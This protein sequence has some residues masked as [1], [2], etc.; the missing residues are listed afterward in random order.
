MTVTEATPHGTQVTPL[1]RAQRKGGIYGSLRQ[2]SVVLTF[3][4][5]VEAA[6]WDELPDGDLHYRLG[7]L[8]T[9]ED[10]A[11]RIAELEEKVLAMEEI[12][13]AAIEY[14]NDEELGHRM[15]TAAVENYLEPD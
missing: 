6:K 2:R 12:V 3:K 7:L 9:P 15:L 10:P 13:D 5:P 14:L 8:F 1:S 11:V 4:T